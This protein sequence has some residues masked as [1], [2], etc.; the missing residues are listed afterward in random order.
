MTA[1][2]PF[3]LID[4]PGSASIVF[5][6]GCNTRCPYCHN[7][8]FLEFLEPDVKGLHEFIESRVREFN[9]RLLPKVEYLIFSG[10]EPTLHEVE[11]IDGMRHAKSLGLKVGMYTNGLNTNTIC[12]MINEG[13]DFIN[14]DLKWTRQEYNTNSVINSLSYIA[15]SGIRWRANTVVLRTTHTP[16]YI[17]DMLWNYMNLFTFGVELV[18]VEEWDSTKNQWVFTSFFKGKGVFDPTIMN[19]ETTKEERRD[20]IASSLMLY[21]DGRIKARSGDSSQGRAQV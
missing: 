8:Q 15:E 3:S 2:L 21:N 20:L 11:I 13:L 7:P 12:K 17:H 5:L 18:P 9:G 16:T 6:P 4:A 14:I 10:G 1:F 19:E